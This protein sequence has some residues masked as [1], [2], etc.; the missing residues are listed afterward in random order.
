M[1]T[2]PLQK[3]NRPL[4]LALQSGSSALLLTL[5]EPG[6]AAWL[7]DVDSFNQPLVSAQEIKVFESLSHL[8]D[9]NPR[10]LKRIISVYALATQVAKLM[11]ISECDLKVSY[12]IRM[13]SALR[14]AT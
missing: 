13:P 6:S 1:P 10:R 2:S 5:L 7:V 14:L 9:P 3:E 11:P 12:A 4:G 8:L